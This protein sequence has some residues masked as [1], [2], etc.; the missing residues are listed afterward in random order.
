LP[1]YFWKTLRASRSLSS[2]SDWKV[3]WSSPSSPSISGVR[4]VVSVPLLLLPDD[5]E[6]ERVPERVLPPPSPPLVNDAASP[7]PSSSRHPGRRE[8]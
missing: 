7:P 4:A 5:D 8:P 1:W 2:S 6:K 3:R